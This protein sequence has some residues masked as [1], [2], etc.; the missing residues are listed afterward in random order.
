MIV[1]K[2]ENA[3]YWTLNKSPILRHFVDAVP[4]SCAD[5]YSTRDI[6]SKRCPFIVLYHKTSLRS[7]IMFIGLIVQ[8]YHKLTALTYAKV[9]IVLYPSTLNMIN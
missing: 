7:R 8:F 2:D 9:G 4:Q 5:N 1:K 3:R 6:K